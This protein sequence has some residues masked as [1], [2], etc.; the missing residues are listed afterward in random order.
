VEVKNQILVDL[1][2]GKE[3]DLENCRG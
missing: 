3:K 1:N 2:R